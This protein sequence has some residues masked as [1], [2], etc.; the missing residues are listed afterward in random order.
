MHSTTAALEQQS[1]SVTPLATMAF[2]LFGR[3]R[4]KTN[5]ELCRA[6]K[7]LLQKVGLEEKP[8]PKV[9]EELARNLAQMKLT[10]QGTTGN[11]I[12][13]KSMA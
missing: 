7:E 5:A 6:T 10:L 2:A 4:Q 12:G 3:N 13:P 1:A 11:N 8:S 9:E